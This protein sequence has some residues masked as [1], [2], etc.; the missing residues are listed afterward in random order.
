MAVQINKNLIETRSEENRRKRDKGEWRRAKKKSYTRKNIY[1]DVVKSDPFILKRETLRDR[2]SFAPFFFPFSVFFLLYVSFLFLFLFCSSCYSSSSSSFFSSFFF[3]LLL[4]SSSWIFTRVCLMA[5]SPATTEQRFIGAI[6][7]RTYDISA[8]QNPNTYIHI[9]WI[10]S[11]IHTKLLWPPHHFQIK[12]KY[13][14]HFI[15]L[16]A[17]RSVKQGRQNF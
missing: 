17:W 1:L 8:F 12:S 4:P 16:Q 14:N 9:H 10:L 2:L 11:V 13:S 3:P 7:K 15:L 5:S 6:I